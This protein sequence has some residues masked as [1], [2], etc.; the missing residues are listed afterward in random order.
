[1]IAKAAKFQKK[2]KNRP[3]MQSSRMSDAREG[4]HSIAA[5]PPSEVSL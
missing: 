1:M 2:V 3:L 5:N 4:R